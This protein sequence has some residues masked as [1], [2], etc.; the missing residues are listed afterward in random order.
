LD[1]IKTVRLHNRAI[2]IALF[3][4]VALSTPQLT[5]QTFAAAGVAGPQRN[6]DIS[7]NT[8]D[9]ITFLSRSGIPRRLAAA[10]ICLPTTGDRGISTASSSTSSWL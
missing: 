10:T 3:S 6:F 1:L 9:L 5:A 4:A 2:P 7:S 8:N